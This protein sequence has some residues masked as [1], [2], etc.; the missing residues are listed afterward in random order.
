ML[1]VVSVV[2]MLMATYRTARMYFLSGEFVVL[3]SHIECRPG[4]WQSQSCVQ[5]YSVRIP[6]GTAIDFI[7][8]RDEFSDG[9][10]HDGATFAKRDRGFYYEVNGTRES[11]PFR[12]KA[13]GLFLFGC[14]GLVIFVARSGP[15]YLGWGRWATK[16]PPAHLAP[17]GWTL[18]SPDIK[19]RRQHNRRH[20]R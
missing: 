19:R 11:W 12:F 4:K 13:L 5:H 14:L 6:D 3:S 7:P 9:A 18:P 20:S 8:F 1:L 15:R 10:L 17:N 16:T 2:L